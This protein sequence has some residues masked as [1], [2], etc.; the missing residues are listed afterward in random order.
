[1]FRRS[2]L[3]LTIVCGL[4]ATLATAGAVSTASG[5]AAVACG[6]ATTSTLQAV[7]AMVANNIDRGELSG[8]ETQ[9]DLGHVTGDAD[10]LSALAADDATATARAVAQIVYHHFWHIVRLRV[11]DAAGRLLAD[12]GG[13]YVI[14]PVDGVL[15][16]AGGQ[17]IGSFVMSVQDDVGFAKLETRAVGDPIGIYVGG[18]LVTERGA[19]FPKLEPAGATVA[20]GG[21]RYSSQTLTY[22]AFPSGTLDAVIALP[23]PTA[24]LSEQSCGAVAVAEIGRVAERLALRFHPLAASYGNFVEV[25]HSET[26]ADV[27]VRI[28]LRVIAGSGGPGP[29]TLPSSGTVSYEDRLWS[30]FTFAP[31]PPARVY[32]LIPAM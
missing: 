3:R 31:T 5:Q 15:R 11:F 18:R 29:L 16:S 17:Q 7:D 20:L 12:V 2:G 8:S 21:L 25:V 6:L 4:L 28:G 32:L 9:V 10:L 26:G 13:P 27:V 19:Q 14:A 23:P 1:M 24:A 22:D 30:V